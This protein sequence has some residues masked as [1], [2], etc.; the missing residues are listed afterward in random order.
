[1]DN[2]ERMKDMNFFIKEWPNKTATLMLE[3][4]TVVWTFSSVDEARKVA[5]EWY[6]THG[7]DDRDRDYQC[8][9]TQD[10]ACTVCVVA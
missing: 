8:Y 10:P 9:T 2:S 5:D 3:D 7:R 6:R 4:G 1:M